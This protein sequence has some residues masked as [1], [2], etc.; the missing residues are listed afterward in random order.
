MA[1]TG[2]QE[3]VTF[4]NYMPDGLEPTE[5]SG[6]SDVARAR[7][8]LPCSFTPILVG[9]NASYPSAKFDYPEVCR[10]WFLINR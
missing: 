4:R 9:G 10:L 1:D 7:Q 3:L 8:E 5:E 2:L 6:L